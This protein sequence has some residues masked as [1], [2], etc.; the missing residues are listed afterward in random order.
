MFRIAS[1]VFLLVRSLGLFS[2][3]Q[4]T[5][6][7]S[8]V[9]QG[10]DGLGTCL[11]Q[12]GIFQVV[13]PS[14]S[15]F[16]EASR[17]NTWRPG[18]TWA[19]SAVVKVTSAQ[20]VS[21][22]VVC[23]TQSQV[24][25]SAR[26][27]SHSFV[28][29]ACR[30]QLI[31]DVSELTSF[32]LDAAQ[33]TVTWGSGH[34]HGEL[35]GKLLNDGLVTPG[36]TETMVGTAGLWLG[37]G[38]GILTQMYGFSCDALRAVEYVDANGQIKIADATQNQD[39]F[40]IA[41]GGGNFF[42]GI[43]TK[44]TAKT[45]PMP[46]NVQK[47]IC[48]YPLSATQAALR[49]W[50]NHIN[51]WSDPSRKLFSGVVIL[52]DR[53]YISWN[54]FSQDSTETAWLDDTI[55]SINAAIIAD[56]ECYSGSLS[57]LERLIDE[58]W[59]LKFSYDDLFVKDTWPNWNLAGPTIA[60][61]VMVPKSRVIDDALLFAIQDYA[62]NTPRTVADLVNIYPM[63][64]SGVNDVD[65]SSTAYGGRDAGWIIHYK[66][67]KVAEN[68][69]LYLEQANEFERALHEDHGLP[70]KGFFNYASHDIPCAP[71]E[72]EWLAAHFS[73]ATRLKEIVLQEDP[74]GRFYRYILQTAPSSGTTSMPTMT[75]TRGPTGQ[76]T[77]APGLQTS[78]PTLSL[79]TSIPTVTP[80][81]GPTGQPI[82]APTVRTSEPT[83]NPT[84][85]I[86]TVTPT[87]NSAGQPTSATTGQPADASTTGQPSV[88]PT[89]DT[90][91][92]QDV[93]QFDQGS[94]SLAG[95]SFMFACSTIVTIFYM[96]C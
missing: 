49:A 26:S 79:S 82:A 36:G 92:G 80:T 58:E 27:G 14:D 43:V 81:G 32:E 4:L 85:L 19:P 42:P 57:W 3:L 12:A 24:T 90:P 70:C 38:R 10:V 95:P 48:F 77:T 46:T 65:P 9:A 76:P 60:G 62:I 20:Q 86:P 47:R 61:S 55:D 68:P 1:A 91:F 29:D 16:Q 21:A 59:A 87:G 89:T 7:R 45:F 64:G 96:L 67:E 51:D 31:I 37:C 34:V 23:A 5:C 25:V 18:T 33:G 50:T 88:T 15:L 78:D 30:G 69:S 75:P 22:A 66:K 28:A 73:D 52:A 54:G 84:T 11:Q 6:M 63:G 72:D 40:W 39:I 41:R 53:L 56:P 17:C 13:L 2:L 74:Q 35:Y 44:F 8:V 83:L 93:S 94:G 71:T